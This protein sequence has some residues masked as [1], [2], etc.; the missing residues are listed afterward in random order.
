M[1]TIRYVNGFKAYVDGY[2]RHTN[3]IPYCTEQTGFM[4]TSEQSRLRDEWFDGWDAAE[5]EDFH[6]KMS[7]RPHHLLTP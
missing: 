3:P 2:P 7:A 1:T 5:L 4:V 6:K